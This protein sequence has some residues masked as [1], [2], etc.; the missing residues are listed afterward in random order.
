M[1]K[2]ERASSPSAI[3]HWQT[4]SDSGAL[5]Q[6][7]GKKTK[8]GC[9]EILKLSFSPSQS[10]KDHD[11]SENDV[12]MKLKSGLGNQTRE[13]SDNS[14]SFT[15]EP[16]GSVSL[17]G[18][19]REM[20]DAV[21]AQLAFLTLVEEMSYVNNYDFFA[22]Y[23]GHGGSRVAHAC[24]DRLHHIVAREAEEMAVTWTVERKEGGGVD[25]EKVMLASFEKMD[26]EV[27]GVGMF[28]LDRGAVS[29]KTMG[30]TAVV[31]VVGKEKI[32]VAN[33]GDSRA[34]LCRGGVAV[35][36]SADH[37]PDR[38]DELERVEAAGGRVINWNGHRVLGVLATSR[39]IGDYYLK[40]FV[41]SKP[42]VTVCE[43]TD[44]DEFLILASDGLW[45]VVSNEVACQVVMRCLDGRMRRKCRGTVQEKRSHERK[46]GTH[47][48]EAAAVLAEMATAR[49]SKDN[50]SVI[51]V[52]L[53]KRG[54]FF[55]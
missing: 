20:E 41:I 3:E 6:L 47:V 24:K 23:D 31:A 25:W 8:N 38:P 26:E 29:M 18:R 27:N 7:G 53:R 12:I 30:S 43:R 46:N 1:V 2:K 9:R 5:S 4:T 28:A 17:I 35:A 16:Y 32:V 15:Y 22:V 11:S 49:G 37:K 39:S 42:E 50:I 21:T 33:C 44:G 45:D 36:L 19:R 52:G 54:G 40:P 34:V 55:C 51:V 48:A 10:S 14:Q 13:K